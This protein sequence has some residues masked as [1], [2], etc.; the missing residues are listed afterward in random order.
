MKILIANTQE[1]CPFIGGV[2]RISCELAEELKSLGNNVSFI[3][4]TKSNYS[5]EYH[6]GFEQVI[7]NDINYNSENN[8]S[9]FRSYVESNGID[10]V[11]NQAANV[12]AFSN[13]C[14]ESISKDTKLI[15]VLH[16]QPD[17]K[18]NQLKYD[19]E[20][21]GR[22]KKIVKFIFYF[23]RLYRINSVNR[24]L[25]QSIF[26]NSNKVVL[27]SESYKKYFISSLKKPSDL[28]KKV[29]SIPNFISDKFPTLKKK[30]KEI[31]FVGRLDFNH[32]R[33]DRVLSVWMAIFNKFPD[34]T[35]KIAGDGPARKTLE[36]LV[37]SNKISNVHFLGFCDTQKEYETA[38]VLLMTSNYEGL[39]MTILEGMMNGCVPI[40][41]HTFG[42]L[43]DLIKHDSSGFLIPPFNEGNYIACLERL[44]SDSELLN[45]MSQ[46]AI[47][48]TRN[49]AMSK[50]V[51][52]WEEV[53]KSD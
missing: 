13:L 6:I 23:P 50:V 36:S 7:L 49:F 9:K 26:D 34:W 14:C 24:L 16:I 40:A 12:P 1:F 38:S 5:G 21:G 19:L 48:D 3:A 33:P 39:P 32:K 52:R 25:Y 30:R 43:D 17:Y 11:I 28:D 45:S 42:A 44:I 47:S 20:V 22:L 41:Y 8:I 29:V 15:S 27:L 37:L 53:L 10:I 31:L 18:R 46:R 35:L 2:E 51:S 4:A